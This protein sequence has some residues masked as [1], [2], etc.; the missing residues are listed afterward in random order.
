M[1]LTVFNIFFS[2]QEVVEEI[3]VSK[4]KFAIFIVLAL[5]VAVCLGAAFEEAREGRSADADADADAEAW[6]GRW[7]GGRWGGGRW[8]G[9]RWGGGWGGGWGRRPYW[10]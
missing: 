10:G 5:L 8:G 7:G 6:R 9:G 3:F 4:M 1:V 2:S